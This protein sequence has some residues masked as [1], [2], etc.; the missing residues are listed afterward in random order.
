MKLTKPEAGVS[1]LWGIPSPVVTMV[2]TEPPNRP[3]VTVAVSWLG[4]GTVVGPRSSQMDSQPCQQGG[5]HQI[6]HHQIAI[7]PA[8]EQILRLLFMSSKNSE[9]SHERKRSRNLGEQGCL[10]KG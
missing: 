8:A 6:Q 2:S 4:H 7:A 1:G 3:V 5:Q 10:P 9:I